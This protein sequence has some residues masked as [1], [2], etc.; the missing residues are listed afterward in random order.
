MV[1]YTI[2]K[3]YDRSYDDVRLEILTVSFNV[4]GLSVITNLNKNNNKWLDKM[5]DTEG[6]IPRL[7]TNNQKVP[8][9]AAL[10]SNHL[11]FAPRP[12][13]SYFEIMFLTV[14]FLYHIFKK[15][16]IK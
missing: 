3:L 6:G 12:M 4:G 15:K 13:E 7:S 5:S 8:L 14:M 11:G 2:L 16:N 9:S 10:A 1:T